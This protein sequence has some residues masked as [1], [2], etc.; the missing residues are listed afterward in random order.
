MG[1]G[2]LFG[3]QRYIKKIGYK[4]DVNAQMLSLQAIKST[5]A[6]SIFELKSS[7]RHTVK[8]LMN[9]ATKGIYFKLLSIY[10]SL[11]KKTLV[12]FLDHLNAKHGIKNLMISI[13][14]TIGFAV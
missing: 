10:K 2:V 1:I 9:Y 7:I 3:L 14:G 8:C 5:F 4:Q 11:T 13:N 12:V 6:K